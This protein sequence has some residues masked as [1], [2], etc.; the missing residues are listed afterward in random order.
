MKVD[1]VNEYPYVVVQF[2]ELPNADIGNYTCVPHSWIRIRRET[3]RKIVVTYPEEPPSI[4]KMRIIN[5]DKPSKNWDL[6]MAIIK[7]ETHSYEDAYDFIMGMLRH[8]STDRY[9]ALMRSDY[10]LVSATAT[11]RYSRLL[12]ST[13]LLES[14]SKQNKNRLKT[15][16]KARRADMISNSSQPSKHPNVESIIPSSLQQPGTVFPESITMMETDG[17]E[18]QERI[19]HDVRPHIDDLL[20]RYPHLHRIPEQ[21]NGI[22]ADSLGIGFQSITRKTLR[23]SRNPL[24]LVNRIC[25][26]SLQPQGNQ[27][28]SIYH[29]HL[30][31]IALTQGVPKKGILNLR[32]FLLDIPKPLTWNLNIESNTSFIIQNPVNKANQSSSLEIPKSSRVNQDHPPILSTQ[33]I[34]GQSSEVDCAFPKPTFHSDMTNALYA[35]AEDSNSAE[36]Q[37]L[38]VEEMV[39]DKTSK[40]SCAEQSVISEPRAENISSALTNSLKS[41]NHSIESAESSV[42]KGPPISDEITS[43][44]VSS[45]ED[46]DNDSHSNLPEISSE[47]ILTA[48]PNSNEQVD[49]SVDSVLNK[50]DILTDQL[51]NLFQKM[52][53]DFSQSCQIADGLHKSLVQSHGVIECIANASKNLRELKGKI[54]A[55]RSK[56]VMMEVQEMAEENQ[57]EKRNEEISDVNIEVDKN[58]DNDGDDDDNDDHDDDNADDNAD[59]D[60]NDDDNVI[61]DDDRNTKNDTDEHKDKKV[62]KTTRGNIRTF[63]LPP[64]YDPDD[65][66]WTLKYR[67][68]DPELNLV[69][70]IPQSNVFINSIKLAHCKRSSKDSKALARMLLVEIFSQVALSVCSLTGARANAFDISGTN[71]RPGLDEPARMAILSF[72]EEYAREKKWGAYDSQSILNTLRSKIQEVRAKHGKTA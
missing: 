66:R 71:V 34:P 64:E 27:Q 28:L 29:D 14:Q 54:T 65:T 33:K 18:S 45:M 8:A 40:V 60:D 22:H 52:E 26:D 23:A 6:Y 63:V 20:H 68:N 30:H 21:D 31:H 4:T 46:V 16:D 70:L 62:L 42:E 56:E 72:V 3:D 37:D 38:G 25:D 51:F 9:S 49:Q 1:T 50:A 61:V 17:K 5:C 10:K 15:V 35:S 43:H 58:E 12:E 44:D 7:L 24:I 67:E 55:V 13:N 32:S 59:D 19:T 41:A 69:E 39:V 53:V 48:S 11:K 36:C 2:L 57:A 47:E